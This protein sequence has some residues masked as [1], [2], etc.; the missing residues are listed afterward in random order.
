MISCFLPP[1]DARRSALAPLSV[2]PEAATQ[3]ADLVPE[4]RLILF[5]AHVLS[6]TLL[7]C[8]YSVNRVR[9]WRYYSVETEYFS[10]LLRIVSDDTSQVQADWTCSG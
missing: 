7:L 9:Y 10:K 8:M 4:Q 6:Q 5:I 3:S 2:V 1:Y